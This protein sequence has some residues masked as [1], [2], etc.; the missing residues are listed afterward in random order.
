MSKKYK[1]LS[2]FSGCGGMDLGF[3]QAGAKSLNLKSV[4]PGVNRPFENLFKI[5]WAND[6]YA[7]SAF[8]YSENFGAQIYSD[9]KSL[10]EGTPRI[11]QGDVAK[12]FFEDAVNGEQIDVVIG[13]FPCQDFSLI[14]G[15]D[16]RL[17][18]QVKRGR[19]YC[20]FVRALA[21]LQP[22]AFVAENVKGLVSVNR[23]LTLEWILN[24]FENLKQR[25]NEIEAEYKNNSLRETV[26]DSKLEG[27]KIL[28]SKVANFKN[29]GIPQ[30]RE[31]LIIIGLRKDLFNKL[32]SPEK[33]MQNFKKKIMQLNSTFSKFPLTPIETFKGNT[34]S[35]LQN[36]YNK[37]IHEYDIDIK[38]VESKRKQYYF[39]KIWPKYKYEIWGDYYWINKNGN[40][41]EHLFEEKERKK[42]EREHKKIL[43]ELD[44]YKK[45]IEE[46]GD[47][48]DNTNAI[49]PEGQPVTER[50]KHIPVGENHEFVRDTKYHVTGLMSNIYKRVHPLKPSATI[51]ARGGG[52]T[53][54]YHY[55]QNRQRLTNRERARLQTFPDNFIF[56]GS[57]GQVR[58][59]IGEAVP[60][61][62]AKK[63]AENL[64]VLL[65]LVKLKN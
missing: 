3:A 34:I 43:I 57:R 22:M 59:Q 65:N 26:F 32:T 25:W 45:D 53:W 37:I 50:M 58:R 48:E 49:M 15:K 13:G 61:L 17:G 1:I 54:G 10:F 38:K 19:L 36:D 60:P 20:H 42:I 16:K 62:A 24:D 44:F 18:V 5:I 21:V 39:D 46:I 14:R 63:I 31:R 47:L 33:I 52:G 8:S 30:G 29:L 23:G 64:Y 2:L 9:P 27:Y 40:N 51:I 12:V 55:S 56:K 11:F 6:I 4:E 35:L 28:F 7:P 41:T